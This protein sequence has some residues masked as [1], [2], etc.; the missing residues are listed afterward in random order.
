MQSKMYM[1]FSSLSFNDIIEI[2]VH[3]IIFFEITLFQCQ[4]NS[5]FRNCKHTKDIVI[6]E[7]PIY[8]SV[9]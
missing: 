9:L 8:F 7:I 6:I 3:L 1:N 5:C 2:K 4:R